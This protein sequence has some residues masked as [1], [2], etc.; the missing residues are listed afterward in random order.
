MKCICWIFVSRATCRIFYKIL[1][2]HAM[3]DLMDDKALVKVER[4]HLAVWRIFGKSGNVVIFC[5]EDDFL[6]GFEEP[7]NQSPMKRMPDLVPN[8]DPKRSLKKN[9]TAAEAFNSSAGGGTHQ[10]TLV[11]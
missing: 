8:L 6:S 11:W 10:A 2:H 7:E 9:F 5:D 4:P 1:M 3:N